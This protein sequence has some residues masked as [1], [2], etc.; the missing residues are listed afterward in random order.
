MQ[1]QHYLSATPVLHSSV[2]HHNLVRFNWGALQASSSA[3]AFMTN[4]KYPHQS[5]SNADDPVT[6]SPQS[7]TLA[8][9]PL[10]S[11][12]VSPASSDI[13]LDLPGI[14]L[15]ECLLASMKDSPEH[16]TPQQSFQSTRTTGDS[17]GWGSFSSSRRVMK[18]G[19]EIVTGSDSDTDSIE[20]LED[21]D[22]LINNTIGANNKVAE[23]KDLTSSSSDV[24]TGPRFKFNTK[25]NIFGIPDI[26]VPKYKNTL[27]LLVSQTAE[28]KK[29]EDAIARAKAAY[30][31]QIPGIDS[32]AYEDG[33]ARELNEDML[34]SAAPEM[35]DEFGLSRVAG[36][37]QRTNGYDRPKLWS[38]FD[39]AS[40][41]DKLEFPR[42]AIAQE[43]YLAMLR[44]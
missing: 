36:A 14:Q 17:S 43:S 37:V 29:T 24:R 38:A 30:E 32:R 8:D 2:K 18:N 11:A 19:K 5:F 35:D 1:L 41:P 21:V 20:S 44:G 42:E 6:V 31:S 4:P 16:E 22:T 23:E 33:Q 10:K 25:T 9:L 39:Q 34:R 28:D 15:Q 7:S 26:S 3:N 27:D 40:I 12:P 13:F